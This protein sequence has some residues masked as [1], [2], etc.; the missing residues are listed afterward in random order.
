MIKKSSKINS[1]IFRFWAESSNRLVLSI[2]A[3]FFLIAVF[4][5][6]FTNDPKKVDLFNTLQRPFGDLFYLGTDELGRDLLSGL[7]HGLRL[8]LKIGLM[9]SGISFAVGAFLGLVSTYYGDNHFRL[10][11]LDVLI[12]IL[13]VGVSYFYTFQ[14]FGVL[15]FN[16]SSGAL[17]FLTRLF[18]SVSF[19]VLPLFVSRKVSRKLKIKSF[20]LPLDSLTGRLIE[21][22][23]A[24][25]KL[26]LIL[27]CAM[28]F[29]EPSAYQVAII[30]G[31]TSWTSIARLTRGEVLKIKY[32]E[33]VE[34]A[35][36]SG[37]KDWRIIWRYIFP[38][39]LT[40]VLITI[41]FSI[42]GAVLFEATLSFL[43]LGVPV[44]EVSLG[45]LLMQGKRN[46][47]AW[48]L[49]VFPGSILFLLVLSL[50]LLGRGLSNALNKY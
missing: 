35:K 31:L 11:L 19:I 30:L 21:L 34:F 28:L 22:F 16:E 48:W 42:S 45:N 38:N 9:A 36:S 5:P 24:I 43:G 13:S 29:D 27:A 4:G 26:I 44:E 20:F 7:I 33:F 25:P 50:N 17:L 37:L 10:S 1:L 6:F 3:V 40:P 8:A 15:V 2:S 14:V 47:D 23:N 32:Q 39:T 41:A 49:I 12:L 18:I 46:M